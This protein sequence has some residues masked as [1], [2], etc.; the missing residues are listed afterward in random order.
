VAVALLSVQPVGALTV[1]ALPGGTSISV[2]N[3]SPTNGQKLLIPLGQ[4]TRDVTDAG[5]AAVGA[6]TVVKDTTI[7]FVMDVSDSMNL[8]AGVDCTGAGVNDSRLVCE[9]QG[10]IVANTAARSATSSVDQVGLAS[11]DG[12][13]ANQIC[14]SAAHDVDL[15]TGGTQLLVD[16]NLDGNGNGTSDLEEVANGL[17]TGGAT[18][19]FGGLQRADEIL[20]GSTNAVNIVIFLSD[21][22]N[23]TGANVST[24]SP[25]NFDSNA[26]IDAFAIGTGVDCTTDNFG[27]G[28]MN[29]V[30][31]KETLAGGSCQQVTDLSKLA[32]LITSAIG[33]TLSSSRSRSTPGASTRSR[34]A[35]STSPCRRT[36]AS[37]RRRRTTRPS[38]RASAPAP[39]RS[40]SGRPA[41]TPAAR[42]TS[43]TARPSGCSSSRSHPRR[44]ATSWEWTTPTP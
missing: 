16:P 38:C 40:A 35:T 8:S 3:T 34:P 20:A 37:P 44:R 14:I 27:K 32:G 41:R 31:A 15:G 30:V 22:F 25:A 36:A 1:G 28:S 23:N 10:V 21:G 33:S 4:P 43:P 6:A 18:C 39:T 17:G 12:D 9:K 24:F 42:A 19:Y 26:R 7:V 5:A 13:F 11:F 2:D 29:D